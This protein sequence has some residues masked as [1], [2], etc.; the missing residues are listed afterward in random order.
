MAE[1]KSLERLFQ[2][3]AKQHEIEYSNDI[4]TPP[5]Y[6]CIDFVDMNDAILRVCPNLGMRCKNSV[7]RVLV[8]HNLETRRNVEF[9]Q[10]NGTCLYHNW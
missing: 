5:L 1:K 6:S 7:A 2:K 3:I 10:Y 4:R 8:V 9:C